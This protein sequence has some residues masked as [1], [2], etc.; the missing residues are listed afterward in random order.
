[1]T[2]I[3]WNITV[4]KHQI[5]QFTQMTNKTRMTV[6]TVLQSEDRRYDRG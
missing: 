4:F 3:I 1:M 6:H 2:K 5:K